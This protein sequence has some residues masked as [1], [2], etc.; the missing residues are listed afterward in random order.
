ML[1]SVELVIRNPIVKERFLGENEDLYHK[2]ALNVLDLVIN[3]IT[4]TGMMVVLSNYSSSSKTSLSTQD[5]E[6]LWW[7]DKYSEFQWL[8]AHKHMVKRYEH[9]PRVIGF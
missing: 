6:G 4:K 7:T 1:Y 2:N 8:D 9:N 5:G 3:R